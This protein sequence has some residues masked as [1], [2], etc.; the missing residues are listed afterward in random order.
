MET[1]FLGTYTR[2][3]SQGVYSFNFD[4]RSG[5][6][7]QL[8]LVIPSGDPFYLAAGPD[9]TL[10][11]IDRQLNRAQPGGVQCLN[12]Q[13]QTL[14]QS[15]DSSASGTY[16]AY[17][18]NRQ[19]VYLANYDLNELSIYEVK[20]HQLKLVDRIADTGTN[21]PQIEQR[22]GPHPHFIN[23]TPDHRLVVCDLGVDTI[24]TYDVTE[25]HHFHLVARHFL[26][27]GFGPRHLRF[28]HDLSIA[29]V[30]GELSSQVATLSYDAGTGQFTTLAIDHTI[31]A[32][33]TAH[34]GAAAIRI[35]SDN[36]FLYVSN[37]GY[38][39]IAVF[40]IQTDGQLS[41]IQNIKVD[42]DFP[43]DIRLTAQDQYLL[44]ANQRSDSLSIFKR[45]AHTGRLTLT[46][47]TFYLPE[48]LAIL[49]S[50][51]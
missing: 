25:T 16:L 41:A 44:V 48:P 19:L 50:P 4:S 33:W 17:D 31:P 39:S 24:F 51:F 28:N 1:F 12:D 45:D 11:C 26:P 13:Y 6:A 40:A 15:F 38:N 27:A 30:V 32:T 18:S 20:Q 36:R 47:N 5:T 3:V 46:D 21:G 22:D 23:Q 35:S 49:P 9:H 8:R 2:R 29:Y 14:G 37:R 34:N 7:Q 10:L 42:G 43:W